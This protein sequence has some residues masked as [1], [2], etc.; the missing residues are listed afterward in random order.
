MTP[1]FIDALLSYLARRTAEDVFALVVAALMLF[2]GWACG[3][4]MR[5]TRGGRARPRDEGAA[6]MIV[7]AVSMPACPPDAMA[8]SQESDTP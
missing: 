4:A 2:A 6:R 1:Q 5:A 3:K 7:S 8:A